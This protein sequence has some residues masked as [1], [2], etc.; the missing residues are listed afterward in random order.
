MFY[1]IAA[2]LM[3]SPHS[4]QQFENYYFMILIYLQYPLCNKNIFCFR[5]LTK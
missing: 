5:Q 3:N 4:T 1:K 2:K